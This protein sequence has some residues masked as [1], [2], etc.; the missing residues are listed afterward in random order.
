MAEGMNLLGL[1]LDLKARRQ[2]D[3]QFRQR[4]LMA[5]KEQ[6]Q[7][8]FMQVLEMTKI[9]PKTATSALRMFI[10]DY[11]PDEEQFIEG[12]AKV[13]QKQAKAEELARTQRTRGFGQIAA[14]GAAE[15]R[16]GR[17]PSQYFQLQQELGGLPPELLGPAM[18][19]ALAIA[20]GAEGLQEQEIEQLRATTGV[21]R[22]SQIAQ[23]AAIE[24]QQRPYQRFTVL[25]KTTG[26][27]RPVIGFDRYQQLISENPNL[28][29]I[30]T[31][32]LT[33][34][35]PSDLASPKGRSPVAKLEDSV[36]NKYAW[37]SRAKELRGLMETNPE[38]FAFSGELL[39]NIKGVIGT[40]ADVSRLPIRALRDS[41][42]ARKIEEMRRGYE[43][44][45][46]S[47]RES[48]GIGPEA[49]Q[50]FSK[51]F[52]NPNAG[53]V[54]V[55]GAA[56]VY[57]AARFFDPTGK[58]VT[59]SDYKAAKKAVGIRGYMPTLDVERSKTRQET[60]IGEL[61]D[62]IEYDLKRLDRLGEKGVE[63]TIRREDLELLGEPGAGVEGPA[64]K[65]TP[66]QQA[67]VNRILREVGH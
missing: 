61:E 37:L 8:S 40:S 45:L 32:S 59:D 24:A 41:A 46:L 14:G 1:Y 60:Y 18:G 9:D 62:S 31:P 5:E 34:V 17:D 4:S 39:A 56:Q 54:D 20:Q 52:R 30:Q 58:T 23:S 21:Q 12:V 63:S 27:L 13:Q 55:L 57:N 65:L 28:I 2:Q 42:L 50:Y 3:E 53:V 44:D 22:R 10:P 6:R 7:Q 64:V 33:A 16:G 29:E 11:T 43:E 15:L 36:S 48:G 47:L 67:E 25:D 51:V 38:L 66:E 35:K 19:R 26:D 49:N